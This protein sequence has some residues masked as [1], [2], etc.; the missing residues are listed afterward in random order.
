MNGKEKDT[1]TRRLRTVGCLLGGGVGDALGAPVEFMR[2]GEIRDRYGKAGITRLESAYGRKGVITDD[3]QMTLFTAEGLILSRI[4]AEY[5]RKNLTTPAIYHAYL[6]WLF[7]Q[8]THLQADLIKNHGTCSVID[9]I[10]T[11]H[12]ELFSRRAPGHSCLSALKSPKMGTMDQPVNNSKGCGGVM[13][14]AP[15]GVAYLDAEKAFQIGCES[16]AITHGHPTG[17][18]SAGFLSAVISMIVSGEPLDQ[19]IVDASQILSKRDNHDECLKAVQ[20]AVDLSQR[21][22]FST[23]ILETLGAGWVAEEALAIGLYCALV[24]DRDFRR[25]VLSAV[26]HSGDSDSTGA[27]TGNII[28]AES[29]T[30]GIPSEWLSDLE[31]RELIEEVADDLLDQFHKV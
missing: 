31:L 2:L 3:T 27:I 5:G 1:P 24:A 9:G 15:I 20:F 6:R 13:R 22:S 19:A 23:E 26:N 30:D 28:G 18:L 10:L 29:G 17:Y 21:K 11:G 8:E 7:T 25:G 14:V 12:R 4:R 16:A